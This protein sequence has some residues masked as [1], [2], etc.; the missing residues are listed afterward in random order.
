MNFVWP[1]PFDK[2]WICCR[3]RPS[4]TSVSTAATPGTA[5]LVSSVP[6]LFKTTYMV[7]LMTHIFGSSGLTDVG[8]RLPKLVKT[9]HKTHGAAQP[10]DSILQRVKVPS[11]V[12]GHRD[13]FI[14]LT[15]YDAVDEAGIAI[16]EFYS[17]DSLTGLFPSR[18][19]RRPC[20]RPV[21]RH[22]GPATHPDAHDA[23]EGLFALRAQGRP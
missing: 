2:R 23:C 17:S 3:R 10:T 9:A 21:A 18:E 1:N 12:G 22:A 4:A 7:H 20:A 8:R 14:D 15:T 6:A 5:G 11:A 13:A 16:A 19:H